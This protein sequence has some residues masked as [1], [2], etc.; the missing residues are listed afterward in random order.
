MIWR[1]VPINKYTFGIIELK[2]E[3]KKQLDWV[4]VE[5]W[6]CKSWYYWQIHL[7]R[8]WVGVS[9]TS[10]IA[11]VRHINQRRLRYIISRESPWSKR[12]SR[13]RLASRVPSAC[14]TTWTDSRKNR[15]TRCCQLRVCCMSR[16][17]MHDRASTRI[18]LDC[19]ANS[20][21]IRDWRDKP[22]RHF[23]EVLSELL[24]LNLLIV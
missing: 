10:C 6:I 15:T 1:Y 19:A 22:L 5:I 16:G 20:W 12:H 8:N 14:E 4:N 23:L 2:S 13:G 24:T 11:S 7:S 21:Y 3:K 18:S 17:I 9:V